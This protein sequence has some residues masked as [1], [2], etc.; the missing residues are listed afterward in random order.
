M[1]E[2]TIFDH[3]IWFC[4]RLTLVVGIYYFP[5]CRLGKFKLK[6]NLVQLV[7]L[8]CDM[9]FAEF[10]QYELLDCNVC[11][12]SCILHICIYYGCLYHRWVH[13]LNFTKF[14][15]C[16]NMWCSLSGPPLL[17][18]P[19]KME[20]HFNSFSIT[21]M[22]GETHSLKRKLHALPNYQSKERRK[23]TSYVKLRLKQIWIRV[24]S[25]H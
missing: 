6:Q 12:K 3:Y 14:W 25:S 8:T 13:I 11:K 24:I 10:I 1:W 4:L 21:T 22:E 7:L 9:E 2:F 23:H 18:Y 19:D 17:I 16:V 20:K 15:D 5:I